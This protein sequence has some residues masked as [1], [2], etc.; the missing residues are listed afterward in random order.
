M[1]YKKKIDKDWADPDDFSLGNGF[2]LIKTNVSEDLHYFNN[3]LWLTIQPS[4]MVPGNILEMFEQE[5]TTTEKSI[6]EGRIEISESFFL[7]AIA[8]GKA[9]SQNIKAI[10]LVNS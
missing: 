3:G 7:K 8:M 5:D 4:N 10:D 1:F 9:N 6:K 2:Y